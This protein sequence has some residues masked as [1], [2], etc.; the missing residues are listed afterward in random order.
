M[1]T[2]NND[3]NFVYKLDC[4]SPTEDL[5]STDIEIY[6]QYLDQAF[7]D[8]NMRNI[9]ITGS[10]GIGK[11]TILKSYNKNRNK[12]FLFISVLDLWITEEKSENIKEENIE[13]NLLKQLLSVYRQNDIPASSL[14][15]IPEDV[16]IKQKVWNIIYAMYTILL[17]I[18]ILFVIFRDSMNSDVLDF[19]HSMKVNCSD[20]LGNLYEKDIPI[21][22]NIFVLLQI[23]VKSGAYGILG[24]LIALGIGIGTYKLISHFSLSKLAVKSD[25]AE[26]ELERKDN[27]QENLDLHLSELIYVFEKVK[28][29]TDCT[30]VFEDLDRFDAKICLSIFVKLRQ[31]NVMVNNRVDIY[32]KKHRI[33]NKIQNISPK[34]FSHFTTKNQY[35]KFVYVC[36]DNIFFKGIDAHK[37]FDVILP[38]IPSLGEYNAKSVLVKRWKKWNIEPTFIEEITPCITDYRMIINIENEYKI[39]ANVYS[40]RNKGNDGFSFSST[41]CIAF[42]VYKNLYPDEYIKITDYKKFREEFPFKGKASD[43]SFDDKCKEILF[44]HI[45]LRTLRFVGYNYSEIKEYYNVILNSGDSINIGNILDDDLKDIHHISDALVWSTYNTEEKNKDFK[46]WVN[47]NRENF[48]EY[49]VKVCAF[50]YE[51]KEEQEA[52]EDIIKKIKE[53]QNGNNYPIDVYSLCDDCGID[54]RCIYLYEKWLTKNGIKFE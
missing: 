15:L 52:L 25:H 12:N 43:V 9:A 37:F 40:C 7:K 10:F 13:Q 29:K 44:K 45:S 54:A 4:L 8:D 3:S 50:T 42:I 5:K 22:S 16:G 49:L 41:E 19:L 35:L 53:F 30:V 33:L 31:I 36:K 11:S 23:V 47:N 21:I 48:L 34:L 24:I 20:Y 39:F 51:N 2:N 14:K 27:K 26:G 32:R 46:E 18:M 28:K 38:V 6:N 17:S 1:H